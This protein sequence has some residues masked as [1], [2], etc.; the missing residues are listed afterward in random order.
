MMDGRPLAGKADAK[1]VFDT[2]V[3]IRVAMAE[4]RNARML[5]YGGSDAYSS[6]FAAM[7]GVMELARNPMPEMVLTRFRR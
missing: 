3:A 5:G 6:S 7:E 4:E 2:L 1:I